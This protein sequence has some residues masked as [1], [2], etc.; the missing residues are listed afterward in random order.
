VLSDNVK[1]L[2]VSQNFQKLVIRQEIE[3]WEDTSLVL[4]VILKSLLDVIKSLIGLLELVNKVSSVLL[5]DHSHGIWE[6]VTLNHLSLEELIDLLELSRFL[7]QLLLDISSLENVFKIDPLLLTEGPLFDQSVKGV[8]VLLELLSL[9]SQRLN[10]SG[11]KDHINVGHTVIQVLIHIINL[12]KDEVVVL[13]WLGFNLDFRPLNVFL[14]Q[15]C[16]QLSFL[17]GSS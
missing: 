3:S 13:E 6:L 15:L 9:I 5:S 2:R 4:K 11:T 12:V 7:S 14:L 17:G 1:I 16:S 8:K 10:E